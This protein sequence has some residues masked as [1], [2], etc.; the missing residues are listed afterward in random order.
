MIRSEDRLHVHGFV[1]VLEH[2]G[3]V[4]AAT[5]LDADHDVPAR[6]DQ[7]IEERADDDSVGCARTRL[8]GAC[9]TTSAMASTKGRV[10]RG[11][12]IG[13]G[14][15][16]LWFL[17]AS[18]SQLLGKWQEVQQAIQDWPGFVL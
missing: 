9:G 2:D 12:G 5:A 7:A 10:K 8:S 16:F 1:Q 6:A 3:A 15:G 13:G 18:G 14:L 11:A 4:H 17:V